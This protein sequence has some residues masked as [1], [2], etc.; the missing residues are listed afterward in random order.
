[1]E[2]DESEESIGR[3]QGHHKGREFSNMKQLIRKE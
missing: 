3:S 1:M 2:E